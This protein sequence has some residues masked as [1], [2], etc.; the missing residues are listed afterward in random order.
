[1]KR[2]NVLVAVGLV[3]LMAAPSVFA[4]KVRAT[5][6]R[7]E[8]SK[9]VRDFASRSGIPEAE[10]A[11]VE[12]EVSLRRGKMPLAA[13]LVAAAAFAVPNVYAER[14]EMMMNAAKIVAPTPIS[15][16]QAK[17]EALDVVNKTQ[18]VKSCELGQGAA[19]NAS[20]GAGAGFQASARSLVPGVIE[21]LGRVNNLLAK[22]GSIEARQDEVIDW[23]MKP[24]GSG[25][26]VAD[27]VKVYTSI[28]EEGLQ[29]LGEPIIISMTGE[30]LRNK[31]WEYVEPTMTDVVSQMVAENLA[32][33]NIKDSDKVT[34]DLI[35][36]P[37]L[38]DAFADGQEV[39]IADLKKVVQGEEL[40]AILVKD[41]VEQFRQKCHKSFI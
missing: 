28:L 4:Q 27:G 18:F 24:D 23:V 33:G 1:M 15:E 26:E 32:A 14:S 39:T 22:R 16:T 10:V 9:D 40:Q 3:A 5:E 12:R 20:V 13:A 21:S 8:I 17:V 41:G 37:K 38:K 11:K 7:P 35:K 6:A 34:V 25:Q 30:Q 19:R 31:T 36:M 2:S 29:Q